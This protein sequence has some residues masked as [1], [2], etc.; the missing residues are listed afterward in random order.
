[1]SFNPNT[2]PMQGW[3][4]I[5]LAS[6]LLLPSIPCQTFVGLSS[7]IMI[8]VLS[9][10]RAPPCGTKAKLFHSVYNDL[11]AKLNKRFNVLRIQSRSRCSRGG[12]RAQSAMHHMDSTTTHRSL[13]MIYG[14]ILRFCGA[15]LHTKM[16]DFMQS[17]YGKIRPTPCAM[18]C[19]FSALVL[20]AFKVC[21]AE[22]PK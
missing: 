18:K 8:W 1:M 20:F 4:V 9:F 21:L 19:S 3:F 6:S 14:R 16:T 7:F 13:W 12:E 22:L 15:F 2:A 5:V 17:L 10:K 11:G